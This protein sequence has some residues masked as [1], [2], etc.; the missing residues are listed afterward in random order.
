MAAVQIRDIAAAAG[1]GT[2]TVYRRFGG[3]AELLQAVI[4]GE[5]HE[6]QEAVLRGEPPLGP[7]APPAARAV[8]FLAALAALT[9]RNLGVL[10]ATDAEPPGWIG[11]GAYAG[12]RHH[13]SNL[14][15]EVRTDLVLEDRG[16]YADALLA[17]LVPETYSLQRRRGTDAERIAANLKDLAAAVLAAG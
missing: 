14:L 17:P 3:K 12:W 4:A 9:E 11:T 8:G 2:G 5:E 13:L 7:D 6:L 16:W 15:A 10:L 1:V